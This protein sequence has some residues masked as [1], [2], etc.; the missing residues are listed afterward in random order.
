MPGQALITETVTT[1]PLPAVEPRLKHKAAAGVKWSALAHL[2]RQGIH[3]LTT[4]VLAWFLAAGD[5][6]L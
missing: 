6:E 3:F 5:Q 1:E 4:A 2:L